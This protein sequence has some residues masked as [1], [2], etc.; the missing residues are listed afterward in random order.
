MAGQVQSGCPIRGRRK[1]TE[2][3]DHSDCFINGG[4][5]VSPIPTE[6]DLSFAKSH[7]LQWLVQL[8]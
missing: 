4:R 1:W 8:C 7:Q 3:G 2:L 5:D 6:L